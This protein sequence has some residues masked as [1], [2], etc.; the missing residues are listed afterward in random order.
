MD[1]TAAGKPKPKS[2]ELLAIWWADS[3]GMPSFTYSQV[4]EMLASG[5]FSR[6][7]G[8]DESSRS[9]LR[10]CM[11]WFIQDVDNAEQQHNQ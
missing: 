3:K 8:F 7:N 4:S 6:I 5:D 10:D 1:A 2:E 11:R 9:L